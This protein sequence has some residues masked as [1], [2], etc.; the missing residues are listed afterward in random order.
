MADRT[1]RDTPTQTECPA[2]ASH[3]REGCRLCGGTGFVSREARADFE[4]GRQHRITG[5][6]VEYEKILDARLGQLEVKLHNLKL[7]RA[8][9]DT[10][11]CA[12]LIDE[13]RA[14]SKDFTIVKDLPQGDAKRT[15]TVVA[16]IDFNERSLRFL[17]G[18]R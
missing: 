9:H 13:G 4:A 15:V 12:T 18:A 6:I 3:N 16:M 2:C 14:L 17:S 7:V 10:S 8:L 11:I 5:Q 1:R